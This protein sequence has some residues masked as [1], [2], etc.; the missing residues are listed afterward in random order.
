MVYLLEYVL[1]H[2]SIFYDYLRLVG[3]GVLLLWG[4]NGMPTH[5]YEINTVSGTASML[6]GFD[7][8]SRSKLWGLLEAWLME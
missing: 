7:L 5:F 8:L 1:R 2:G 4:D 3:V 6:T